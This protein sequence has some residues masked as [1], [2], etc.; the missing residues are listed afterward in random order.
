MAKNGNEKSRLSMYRRDF[1]KSAGIVTGSVGA[2]TLMNSCGGTTTGQSNNVGSSQVNAVNGRTGID[3]KLWK[4]DPANFITNAVNDFVNTAPTNWSKPFNHPFF[5]APVAIAFGDGDAQDYK[6]IK[7]VWPWTMTPRECLEKVPQVT[8]GIVDGAPKPRSSIQMPGSRS[9]TKAVISQDGKTT[10]PGGEPPLPPWTAASPSGPPLGAGPT[11]GP[12]GA[13]PAGPDPSAPPGASPGGGTPPGGGG[14]VPMPG[15]G[16]SPNVTCI[17]IGLPIHPDTLKA[18]VS[19]P[20]GNSP[21]MKAMSLWGAHIGFVGDISYYIVNLLQF[22]GEKAIAPTFTDWAHEMMMDFQYEGPTSRYSISPASERA[23]AVAA[24]L[25]TYGLH[26]MVITKKGTAVILTTIMTS[27]KIP[28]TPKPTKEYCPWYRDGSC[29]KCVDRCPGQAIYKKLPVN[30]A[31]PDGAPFPN[32]KVPT[33]GRIAAKCDAGS[34]AA[35]N[36]NQTYLKDRMAK[37]AGEYAGATGG[38]FLGSN[39]GMPFLMFPAC[40]KCYTNVPC[41]TGIPE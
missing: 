40:G 1:L 31:F 17:S 23:W 29:Y 41:A 32:G 35:A 13:P 4:S 38:I 36:Y 3:W 14:P 27:A 19:Y 28:P 11:G 25:G 9:N 5:V 24:G 2:L 15:A 6:N 18:E 20:Y 21:E 8:V 12:P 7:S 26:D 30:P 16:P 10:Y 22:L 33:D 34:G 37:E 39:S